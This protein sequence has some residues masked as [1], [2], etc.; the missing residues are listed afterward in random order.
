MNNHGQK[1][2]RRLARPAILLVAVAIVACHRAPEPFMTATLPALPQQQI[3]TPASSPPPAVTPL[4]L[5]SPDTAREARVE[6]DT[7]GAEVDVRPILDFLANKAGVTLVY[8]PEI[9]KKVR[10]HLID[11]PVSQAIQTVLSLANLTLESPTPNMRPPTNN[12]VVFYSLPV[13]VDSLSVE[14]IMKA[15][16]VGRGTAELIVRS[17]TNKPGMP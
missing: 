14:A 3:S 8:S 6:V 10:L 9:N 1:E 4:P 5:L 7:H 16:G 12:A 13:N 11:V 17:R 2:G 15:F